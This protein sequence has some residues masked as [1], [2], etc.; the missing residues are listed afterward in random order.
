MELTEI[1]W[2]GK[3]LMNIS[4]NSRDFVYLPSHVRDREAE[5]CL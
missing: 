1:V 4:S 5:L 3:E 2:L